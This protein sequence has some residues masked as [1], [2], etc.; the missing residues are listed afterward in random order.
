MATHKRLI[1]ALSAC[2]LTVGILIALITVNDRQSFQLLVGSC[3]CKKKKLQ[4]QARNS[5]EGK[6]NRRIP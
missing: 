4:K 5:D 1:I 6:Y 3:S 2:L